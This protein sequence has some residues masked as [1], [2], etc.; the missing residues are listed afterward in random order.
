MLRVKPCHA[1]FDLQGFLGLSEGSIVK[2]RRKDNET[3]PIGTFS[4]SRAPT[5][6]KNLDINSLTPGNS[7]RIEMVSVYADVDNFT[8]YVDTHIDDV[9]ED[10]LRCLHVIR[11]ELNRVLTSDFSDGRVRFISGCIHGHVL[12]GS[13][14]TTD[15]DATISTAVHCAGGLRSSFDS[16]G[17]VAR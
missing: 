15:T 5:P 17:T 12:E 7:R 14:Y 10:A 3:D 2:E 16:T 13:A 1:L 8:A 11:A 9:P 6:L 4:I